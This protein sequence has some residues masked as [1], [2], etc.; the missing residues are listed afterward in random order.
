MSR[1]SGKRWPGLLPKVWSRPSITGATGSGLNVTGVNTGVT[2]LDVESAI[3]NVGSLYFVA[4]S[5]NG[6][7]VSGSV[8]AEVNSPQAP[9]S[10][11]VLAAN[12]TSP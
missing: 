5:P 8:S 9:G 2:A 6:D 7:V 12:L 4:A 11:C 1:R 10:D 3:N